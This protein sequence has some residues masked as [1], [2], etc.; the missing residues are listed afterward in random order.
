MAGTGPGSRGASGPRGTMNEAALQAGRQ[1]PNVAVVESD[2]ELR[3]QVLV[4]AL[5]NAGFQAHGMGGAFELYRAMSV[6][7]YDLVL[8]SSD[9]PDEDGFSIAN[10]LRRLPRRL[11]IVMLAGPAGGGRLPANV[12][13]CLAKPAQTDEVVAVLRHVAS[14]TGASG[15]NVQGGWRLDE[16]S[17]CI[18]APAGA[19]IALTLAERRLMARLAATPGVPVRREELILALGGS[20]ESG[21]DPHRLEML[22]YRLRRKCRRLAGVEL[23]L[24]AVRGMG[25]VLPW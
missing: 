1:A 6:N 25:Y 14:Q 23:P 7:R 18:V 16:W 13:A 10:H 19:R 2:L 12:D 5:A 4:P 8:L 15:V 11:G 17:W 20:E 21:F 22:V 24:R 3:E 9:L